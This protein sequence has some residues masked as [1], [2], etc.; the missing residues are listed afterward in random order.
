VGQL[1]L[2][3]F[4]ELF[5]VLAA[6][7]LG[8][9]SSV[10]VSRRVYFIVYETNLDGLVVLPRRQRVLPI[11]AG[12]LADS[13]AFSALTVTAASTGPA[14]G[15]VSGACLAL[16]FTVL[17]RMAWQFYV[18]LRTDIYYL[19][20]VLT[21]ATA[22]DAAGRARLSNAVNRLRRHP[23]RRDMSAFHPRDQR[24]AGWFA[25]LLV[26]GY[27]AMSAMFLLTL[28]VLWQLLSSSAERAFVAHQ[29]GAWDAG[30]FGLLVLGQFTFAAVL[31]VKR[32]H[33]R[34]KD[35]E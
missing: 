4:H 20:T 17:P 16:A 14:E 2:A 10:R 32:H 31:R 12:L 29:E 34:R 25:S 26:V 24:A 7:R 33:R 1:L 8:V 11:L 9:R 6:R 35:R 3:G 13:I 30:I 23:V 28:P 27:G 5:H 22:L 19:L 18:F 21:G 15:V